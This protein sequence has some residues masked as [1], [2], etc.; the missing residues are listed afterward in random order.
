VSGGREE[1]DWRALNRASWDERVPV[2]V[3]SDFYDVEGFKAGTSHLRAVEIDEVG[4]VTGRSLVH[5][6]CHFGLDTLS[7]AREGARVTGLDFSAPA[8]AAARAL[9][10]ELGIDAD[11]VEADVYDAVSAL[12]GRQFDVV[13]TGRGAL[14]WLPDIDAWAAVV[15]GLVAPGGIVYLDE[16]HPL[17]EVFGDDDLTVTY[18]Y[19]TPPEGLRFE[20]VG[21][22]TD[23]EHTPEHGTQV[24]WVHPVGDVVSALIGAGLQL[25]LLHEWEVTYWRRWPFLERH[26]DGLYRLPAGHPL[27]PLTYSLRARKPA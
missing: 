27:I 5:L 26:D 15:A 9:A 3:A 25:E 8:V 2:H 23:G 12:E 4:D 11:F 10:A 16:F 14:N 18:D 20:N 24:E 7:W 21:T 19:R 17:S 13:Y 1:D 22:Y 6:Q